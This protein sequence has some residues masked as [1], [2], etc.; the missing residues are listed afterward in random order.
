MSVAVSKLTQGGC[1][2]TPKPGVVRPDLLLPPRHRYAENRIGKHRNQF[3]VGSCV[4]FSCLIA[5]RVRPTAACD[6]ISRD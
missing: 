2:Y 1:A 6:L 3:V 5:A 4:V